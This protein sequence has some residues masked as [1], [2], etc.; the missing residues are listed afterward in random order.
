MAFHIRKNDIVEVIC[1][2]HRGARGKVLRID[3]PRGLVIVE[4]VNMVYRHVR[5]TRR[6][7][8]GGRVQKEAPVHIS[9]VLP[10]DSAAGKGRRVRFEVETTENGRVANKRRVT[11]GG[12]TLHT[13]T[14][15]ERQAK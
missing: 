12:T 9:N 6:N 15:A 10:Y 13:L 3:L 2:D 1:G 4:G 7:P 5:P 11:T 14:R 8:Q